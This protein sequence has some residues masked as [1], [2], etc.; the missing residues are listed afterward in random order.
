MANDSHANGR[1]EKGFSLVE[2]L[3]VVAIIAIMAAVALPN[4]GNYVRN[5][6]VKGGAQSVA[7]L[8]QSA[9]GKAIATNTNTGVSFF[10]LDDDS[11]RFVQEDLT[12]G[13][14]P[15]GP[16]QEL[17][18]G[19][20]FVVATAPNSGPSIRFTR[21][22]GFCNPG[23]GTCAAAFVDPCGTDTARCTA[24]AGAN[25]FAPQPDGTLVLTLLEQNT[26]LR[27]MVRI[28][29]GGRVLPQP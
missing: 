13:A 7:S 10:V 16:I 1:S 5:Y 12:G 15:R 22:G 3:I 25:F 9:R 6:R 19:V 4:I 26:N 24:N 29:P 21:M 28:A 11:Y 20:R 27:K 18:L 23:V 2:L 17:P 8:L 14:Q